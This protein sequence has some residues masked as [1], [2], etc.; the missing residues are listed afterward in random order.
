MDN[1]KQ[2][3]KSDLVQNNEVLKGSVTAAGP[4]TSRPKTPPPTE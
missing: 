3:K 4:K 1:E 2:T